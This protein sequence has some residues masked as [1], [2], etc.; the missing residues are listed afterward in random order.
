VV[1]SSLVLLDGGELAPATFDSLSNPGARVRVVE[2]LFPSPVVLVQKVRGPLAK[3][4]G[5]GMS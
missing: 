1:T 3:R 5:T 2:S 4:D